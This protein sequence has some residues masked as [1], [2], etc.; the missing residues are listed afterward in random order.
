MN[1]GSHT[2]IGLLSH[3]PEIFRLRT[4]GKLPRPYS[5]LRSK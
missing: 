1:I 5:V 3:T 2:L 4:G